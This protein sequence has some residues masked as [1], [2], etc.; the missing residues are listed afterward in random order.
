MPD[1]NVRR[2][3]LTETE[4]E[5]IGEWYHRGLSFREIGR[6]LNRDHTTI[7]RFINREEGEPHVRTGRPR[8]LTE[9]DMRHIQNAASNQI[10]VAPRIRVELDLQVSVR[11]VQ[12]ALR[13]CPH[14]HRQQ[15]TSAPMLTDASKARRV[16]WAQA[17]LA[18]TEEW[19]RVVFSDEK[20]FNLDGPDGYPYYYHDD[21]KPERT[22][23]RRQ[24]GGGG[25]MMWGSFG[26]LG[27]S[28]IL[29]IEGRI[30]GQVYRDFIEDNVYPIMQHLAV[31]PVIFQQDNAPAHAAHATM[32]WFAEHDVEVLPWPS[33]SPD[34]NPMENVWAWMVRK[35]YDNGARQ[36][37]SIPALK[38]AILNAWSDLPMSMVQNLINSMPRRC[39][40]RRKEDSILSNA[41]NMVNCGAA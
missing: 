29:E 28:E 41:A 5:R 12:Q 16:E 13:H 27:L 40:G 30:T 6:L 34:L 39:Q 17:H 15:M 20:K 7:I 35:V 19:K 23:V 4:K 8:L 3:E 26:W 38:A 32:A 33:N 22:R 31:N 18:W 37:Y 11:T 24:A 10:V 21:R 25:V 14:L 36:F 9:R 2:H 1:E